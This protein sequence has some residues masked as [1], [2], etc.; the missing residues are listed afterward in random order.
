[1]VVLVPPGVVALPWL[2]LVTL[3][4]LLPELVLELEGSVELPVPPSFWLHPSNPS[5][6]TA[7]QKARIVLFIVAFLVTRLFPTPLFQCGFNLDEPQ[8]LSTR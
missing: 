7:A 4:L 8:N 5:I 1:M 6:P 2:V 3:V